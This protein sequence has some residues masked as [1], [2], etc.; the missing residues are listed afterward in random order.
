[1]GGVEPLGHEAVHGCAVAVGV[2]VDGGSYLGLVFQHGAGLSLCRSALGTTALGGG[3]PYTPVVG[4]PWAKP[5]GEPCTY[6]AYP[7][8]SG[9]GPAGAIGS[10]VDG[11]DEV[12]DGPA[13]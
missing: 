9:V 3:A 4:F 2:G 10:V 5:V 1:M 7:G 11:F 13:C 8:G 12:A 6:V